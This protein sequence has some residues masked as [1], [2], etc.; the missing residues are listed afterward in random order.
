MSWADSYRA[1]VEETDR[2]G[3]RR[4][5]AKDREQVRKIGARFRR[6]V[7]FEELGPGEN[8]YF[9]RNTGEIVLSTYMT[10]GTGAV[11]VLV[12]ELTHSAELARTYQAIKDFVRESETAKKWL[13]ENGFDSFEQYAAF[14]GDRYQSQGKDADPEAEAVAFFVQENLFKSERSLKELESGHRGILQKLLDLVRT[15]LG[16]LTGR[17]SEENELRRVERMLEKALKETE[18]QMGQSQAD[19]IE[20]RQYSIDKYWERSIDKWDGEDHQSYFKLGT[21]SQV[22]KNIGVAEGPIYFDQSKAA[23]ALA[24]HKEI[25]RETLKGIPAMLEN[26]MVVAASYDNSIVAMGE[27]YGKNG[28]PVVVAIKLDATKRG[29]SISGVS[30]VRSI[31]ERRDVHLDKLLSDDA[32]LYLNPNKNETGA[33]FQALGRSTPVGGT[34]FGLIQTIAQ[35]QEK[36]NRFRENNGNPN[37]EK[38]QFDLDLSEDIR[39]R[40]EERDQKTRQ[41]VEE[42]D[43]AVRAG[44]QKDAARREEMGRKVARDIFFAKL[45]T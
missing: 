40:K 11:S 2:Y 26:P 31:G 23:K 35:A 34:K 20:S 36:N 17:T 9:D 21:A 10:P 29:T 1:D 13:Q 8:G 42:M 32:I 37:A 12:H 28:R 45:R 39:R 24:E 14:L 19:G 27:L 41:A 30:K 38:R 22:L 6:N 15:A 25:S 43:Q 33:W 16:Q 7:R 3:R 5:S 4:V 18:G 44:L